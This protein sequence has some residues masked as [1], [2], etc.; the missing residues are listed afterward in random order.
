MLS[1]AGMRAIQRALPPL[2]QTGGEMRGMRRGGKDVGRV[3]L[4]LEDLLEAVE[5]VSKRVWKI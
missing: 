3:E 5:C 4:L 1:D 2:F